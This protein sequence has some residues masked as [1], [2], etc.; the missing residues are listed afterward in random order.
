MVPI[1]DQLGEKYKDRD[2]I[3]IAKMDATANELEHTKVNS[4]PTIKLYRKGTNQVIEYNGERTLEG[5][6]K[7]L[8][9]EGEYGRAAPDQVIQFKPLLMYL[10]LSF[11]VSCAGESVH[12]TYLALSHSSVPWYF[13]GSTCPSLVPLVLLWFY[14]SFFGDTHTKQGG[15]F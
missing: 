14:L 1:Y 11:G 4:F 12:P 2:D 10:L 7:F 13:F 15:G 6:T 5:L 9:S 8:E 3:V